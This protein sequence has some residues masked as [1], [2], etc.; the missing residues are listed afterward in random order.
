MSRYLVDKFIFQV[1]RSEALL[2]EYINDPAALV[3]RWEKDY[4][5][6]VTEIEQTSA[7]NF[8]EDERH[9]LATQDFEKLYAMGAN[10]F[11]LWTLML[12]ILEKRFPGFPAV[13][14]H[15][16]DKIKPY[17]RPDSST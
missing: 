7:H 14:A 9:A 11:L 13:A 17:G 1:D 2:K 15:Y 8:T 6:K 10:S 16:R 12:P 4:A 3:A 5:H